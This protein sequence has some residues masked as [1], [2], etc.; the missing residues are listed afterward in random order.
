[1]SRSGD[2]R[3]SRLQVVSTGLMFLLSGLAVLGGSRGWYS[4]RD[5]WRWWPVVFLFPAVQKLTAPPPERNV[6]AGVAWLTA[7][8]LTPSRSLAVTS[9]AKTLASD[10]RER[11]AWSRRDLP[12]P[13][14]PVTDTTTLAPS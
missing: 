6:F 2:C 4:V 12:T 11:N 13:C 1:M 5:A 14:S 8:E 3:Q 7:E 10:G 9:M